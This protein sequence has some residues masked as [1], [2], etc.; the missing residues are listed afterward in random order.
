MSPQHSNREA[1]IEGALRCLTTR[2]RAAI[3]AR[4]IAKAAGANLASIGYHFGSKDALLSTALAQACLQWQ[5]ALAQ[6]ADG[7]MDAPLHSRVPLLVNAV[8]P[9][10]QANPGL[11]RAFFEGLAGTHDDQELRQILVDAYRGGRETLAMLL[12]PP[13]D[14][15]DLDLASLVLALLDGFLVQAV[16]DQGAPLAFDDIAKAVR[17]LG[18]HVNEE[19]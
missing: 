10:A 6:F 18:E 1:L 2:P 9:A 7:L 15:P 3:T 16:V 14:A 11:V 12:A 8:G 5:A 19:K 17:R 4:D 13:E